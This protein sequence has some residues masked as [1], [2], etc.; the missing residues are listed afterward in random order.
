MRTQTVLIT[1]SSRGLGRSLA[2]HF[3]RNGYNTILHG[4]DEL[5]LQSV[6]EQVF[7]HNGHCDLVQGDLRA[8]ET[9]LTLVETAER[10]NIDMLINNAG[11]YLNAPFQDTNPEDLR[12]LIEV[13]LLAPMLLTRRVFP[14][15]QRK[16]SGLIVNINS[17][18]G[19]SSNDRESAYC[20]SKHGLRGFT[21][22]IQFEANRYNIHVIDVYLGTMNTNVIEG[23]RDP[24]KCIQTEEA[25]EFIFALCKR[26]ESLRVTE[27]ELTRTRY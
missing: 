12:R 14:I 7:R 24:E 2:I 1:G 17:L 5:E 3:A 15:L 23:R 27:V 8:D 21:R 18:A 16:Q 6:A 26:Y 4:R 11:I 20:A 13:N 9:I 22:S 25:A 19:K 10:R